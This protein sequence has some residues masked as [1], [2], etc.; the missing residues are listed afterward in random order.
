VITPFV[1]WESTRLGRPA[2]SVA[3]VAAACLG[4]YST[5]P[6]SHLELAARIPGYRP[7]MLDQAYSDRSVVGLGTL[8][9]SG[10]LLPVD[11]VGIATSATRARRIP[12]F[13]AYLKRFLVT[14]DYETWA[15][16]VEDLLSDHVPRG[17]AR[18]KAELAPPEA[19]LKAMRHVLLQ[20]AT[21]CRIVG[22]NTAVSWRA[23]ANEYVLWNDW[24]PEVDPFGDAAEAQ[25]QLAACYLAAWGPATADDFAWWAGLTKT[26]ATAALSAC[27]TP[28]PIGWYATGE[29]AGVKPPTGVRLLPWWDTLFVTWK[30]RSRFIPEDVRPFVYDRD[31]NA[32]SVVLVDGAVAGV[33]N[34]GTGDRDLEIAAA[35]FDRFTSRQ[36]TAIEEEA[37]I[38]RTL[39]GA[40]SVEVVR[41]EG[42]P[43]LLESRRNLFLR[44]LKD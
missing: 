40:T 31:G 13:A 39:A 27:A 36:W 15:A 14:D 25:V 6:V 22:T 30:D 29:T 24:L 38:L 8:R 20:M 23:G 18:I 4:L 42:P 28:D 11:L 37:E 5:P 19:D 34:L 44:P 32:T 17:T 35:P 2:G 3:E 26:Q 21:E 12:A 1:P 7:A 43:N 16:R 41:R 10:F 9:G 33:W